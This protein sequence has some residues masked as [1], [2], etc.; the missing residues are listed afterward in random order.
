MAKHTQTVKS[1]RHARGWSQED[2]ASIA[3]IRVRTIQRIEAGKS[4]SHESLKALANAFEVDVQSLLE[5]RVLDGNP[6]PR[7]YREKY[8]FCHPI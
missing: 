7:D 3:D 2:L 4:A 5:R 1:L 6:K 8:I